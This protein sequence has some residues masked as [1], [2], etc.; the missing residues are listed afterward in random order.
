MSTVLKHRLW[1]LDCIRFIALCLMLVQHVT[2]IWLYFGDF[3]F[4]EY[5]EII[6][7]IGRI[8]AL[9]FLLLVGVSGYLSYSKHSINSN[10]NQVLAHFFRRGAS[11]F[12]LGLV[13]TVATYIF[14]RPMTIW[15]GVLHF[16][17]IAV[18]VLPLFI[19]FKWVSRVMI[20]VAIVLGTVLM[21]V[22]SQSFWGVPIGFAPLPFNTLDYWPFFPWIAVVLT[23]VETARY[24]FANKIVAKNLFSPAMP[25]VLRP[26]QW[27]G[28]H[29]LLIYLLHVPIVSIL[30]WLIR[31]VL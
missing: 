6:N 10:F 13:L 29:T 26:I 12:S 18:M 22:H 25:S 16:I 31:Q 2:V 4:A 20:I 21:M 5:P 9:L 19:R 8:G 3:T 1:E 27:L 17:G 14:I 24:M 15:F 23:G 28:S 7:S 11:I 30:F